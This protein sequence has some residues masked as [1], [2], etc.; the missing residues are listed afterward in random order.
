M[1]LPAN[2]PI[3]NTYLKAS[4]LSSREGDH[5]RKKYTF[6]QERVYRLE[7]M[8]EGETPVLLFILPLTNFPRYSSPLES[9]LSIHPYLNMHQD[10]IP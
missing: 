4:Y 6:R 7:N 2:A 9:I 1:S 3:D 10:A 8:V 5:K